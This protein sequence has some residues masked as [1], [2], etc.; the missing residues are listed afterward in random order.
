[1][2]HTLACIYAEV[3]KTREAREVLL[4]AMDYGNSSNP[5]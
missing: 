4:Q 2:L 5:I 3:G 1:M